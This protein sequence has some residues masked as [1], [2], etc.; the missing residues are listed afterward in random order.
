M[1]AESHPEAN[2]GATAEEPIT[3][4]SENPAIPAT[5]ALSESGAMPE[6]PATADATVAPSPDRAG[7]TAATAATPI[8]AKTP[9]HLGLVTGLLRM[10]GLAFTMALFVAG[11]ALGY[12]AFQSRQAPPEGMPA[13]VVLADAAPPAVTE[14]IAALGS[15]DPTVLRAAVVGDSYRLL[16]GELQKRGVEEVLEVEPLGTQVFGPRAATEIIV[17]GKQAAGGPILM[18]LVVHTQNGVITNFR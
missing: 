13:P 15:N 4:A 12:S 17:H 7:S 9:R 11:I 6:V 14:F 1:T 5:P 3:T 10:L 8:A 16:V 18:N 2:A